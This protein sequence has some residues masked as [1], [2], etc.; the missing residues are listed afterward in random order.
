MGKM[1]RDKGARVER[2]IAKELGGMRVP[3]S[4]ATEFAKGDVVAHG[5][6]F[7]VKARANGFKQIYDWLGK[8]DALIIKADRKEALVVVPISKFKEMLKNEPSKD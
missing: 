5:L 4:G 2:E 6:T 3:L 8:N 1:Q 7:E